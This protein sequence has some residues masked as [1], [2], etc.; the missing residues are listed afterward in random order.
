MKRLSSTQAR[1]G[2]ILAVGALAIVSGFLLLDVG[3]ERWRP[4]PAVADPVV[5]LGGSARLE[6]NDPLKCKQ[7]MAAFHDYPLVWL[8]D[9][10]EGLSLTG[11]ERVVTEPTSYGIPAT[12]YFFIYYGDCSPAQSEYRSCVVPLQLSVEPACAPPLAPNVRRSTFVVRDASAVE[13]YDGS[14]QIETASLKV[15]VSSGEGESGSPQVRRAAEQLRGV[16]DLTAGLS[17][18]SSLNDPS[19]VL[20]GS[21]ASC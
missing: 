5:S 1:F 11:C 6:S 20:T 10:F 12:D 7:V 9:E 16:N 17:A 3:R 2:A 21:K 8:G 4:D 14:V 18:T 19:N 15:Y 13:T